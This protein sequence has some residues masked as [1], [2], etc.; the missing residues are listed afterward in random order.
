[1]KKKTRYGKYL[2]DYETEKYHF[3]TEA[4]L[5]MAVDGNKRE[6]GKRSRTISQLEQAELKNIIESAT[7]GRLQAINNININNNHPCSSSTVTS[8]RS[9]NLTAGGSHANSYSGNNPSTSQTSPVPVS[10]PVPVPVPATLTEE[11]L[12][13]Q[14]HIQAQTRA[15]LE[16]QM[17]LYQLQKGPWG[18][19]IANGFIQPPNNVLPYQLTPG[20]VHVP[21]EQPSTSP[22]TI[23]PQYE[24]LNLSES[25]NDNNQNDDVN[26]PINNC[27]RDDS[28]NN[29]EKLSLPFGVKIEKAGNYTNRSRLTQKVFI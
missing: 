27:T 18:R 24:A 9:V 21:E 6:G 14:A 17:Y 23:E 15:Q 28:N 26:A 16:F 3:S 19:L 7:Q 4:E 25:H 13:A 10:V 5:S 1:M 20:I 8:S 11:D 2:Y 22:A 29:E 12:Q